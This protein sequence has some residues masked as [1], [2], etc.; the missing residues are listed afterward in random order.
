MNIVDHQKDIDSCRFCFMCRHVCSIA[1]VTNEEEK[2]PRVRALMLS[3]ILRG[4]EDYSK[5]IAESIYQCCLCHY[6][7]EWCQGGWDLPSAIRA[8]RVD[9]VNAG[10]VPEVVQKVKDSLIKYDN[11]YGQDGPVSNDLQ[12]VVL[13]NTTPTRTLLLLG[14]SV[15]YLSPEIGLKAVSLLNKAGVNFV[16]LEKEAA[17]AYE[18]YNLGYIKEAKDKTINLLDNIKR[19]GCEEVVTLSGSLYYL[20]T[21]GIKM[22]DLKLENVK[23]Y[24]VTEYLVQLISDGKLELKKS[25][26]KKISYHESDYLARYSRLHDEPRKLIEKIEGAEYVELRWNKGEARS[27]G[28]A[29][30]KNTYPDLANKLLKTRLDEIIESGVDLLITASGENKSSFINSPDKP[31]SLQVVDIVELIDDLT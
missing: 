11:A 2:T 3:M 13:Q 15:L 27:I 20:L 16:V 1:R 18:L 23:V 7:K 22:M 6:C 8:A 24:H 29:L 28:S 9:L 30:I 5:D 21:E 31:S 19:S 10:L 17:S 25:L 4:A 12:Q 14:S 26:N